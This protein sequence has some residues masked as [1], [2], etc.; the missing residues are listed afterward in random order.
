MEVITSFLQENCVRI[1][2]I[3]PLTCRY[4]AL[5]LQLLI[6]QLT[7]SAEVKKSFLRGYTCNASTYII[8]LGNN[9]L[10]IIMLMYCTISCSIM[11]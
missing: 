9:S 5:L 3:L 10:G 8:A 11:R 2:I 1:Q 6:L 7:A 4:S